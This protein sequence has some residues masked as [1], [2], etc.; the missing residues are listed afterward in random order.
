VNKSSLSPLF[1]DIVNYN[2]AVEQADVVT[3]LVAHKEF[4]DLNVKTELDFCGVTNR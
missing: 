4:K 1:F 3:F 2:E